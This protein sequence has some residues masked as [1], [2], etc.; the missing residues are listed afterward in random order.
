MIEEVNAMVASAGGTTR[1]VVNICSSDQQP[2]S[3]ASAIVPL[4]P[5]SEPAIVVQNLYKRYID[6]DVV[7]GVSFT[8]PKG[9]CFGIL[10]PNGAGKT[11]LLGMIEGIVPITSGQ[12]TML[13]MDVATNIRKIQPKLG[14]QLQSSSYFQFLSVRELLDFFTDFRA[15][16]GGKRKSEWAGKLLGRLDL[17]DKL[18]L[19]ANQLSGGQQ[20]RF[21]I[22]LALLGDPEILFLDE[23]S[24]ALDPH[25]RRH[26]WEFIEELKKERT[27]TIVLTTHY[28][29][30]ASVR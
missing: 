21:S 18:K 16:A 8:V 15:A 5:S 4:A 12:I 1:N 20:Q 29:E 30:E 27:R 25:S 22:A 26:L 17:S 24:A 6:V 7:K 9:S 23:P 2:A 13:G 28:M 3:S 11:S 14:V 19:K 10:G